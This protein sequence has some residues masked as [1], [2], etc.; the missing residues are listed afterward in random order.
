MVNLMQE[1]KKQERTVQ[2]EM[3]RERKYWKQNQIWALV[4]A[5]VVLLNLLGGSAFS[6]ATGPEALTLTLHD[7]KTCPIP[8]SSIT[9]VQLLDEPQYGTMLEGKQTRQG[10]SGTWEHPEW[11]QYT[12]CT[13]SSS[14]CAV[15]IRSDSQCYVANL[16]SSAE[17]QQL[18]QIILEKSPVSK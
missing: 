1:N 14:S 17:T 3:A 2:E 9:E 4:L 12:L 15:W 11:G 10:N 8:Y 5:A 13:Y 7:G 18:Y 16:S 6:V